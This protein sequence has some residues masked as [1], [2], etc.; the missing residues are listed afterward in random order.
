MAYLQSNEGSS[1]E[2]AGVVDGVLHDASGNVS[3]SSEERNGIRLVIATRITPEAVSALI[4]YFLIMLSIYT[5]TYLFV[6]FVLF[7]SFKTIM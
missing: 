4:F 3:Q 7:I 2:I 6:L 5:D 1:E